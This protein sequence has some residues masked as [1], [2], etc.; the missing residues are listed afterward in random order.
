MSQIVYETQSPI[1][2]ASPNGY[3]IPSLIA[4]RR[5][6]EIHSRYASASHNKN[7]NQN[8]VTTLRATPGLKTFINCEPK[9]E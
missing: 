5:N 7:E 9:V 6:P 1:A 8:N 2:V 4:S 3:E